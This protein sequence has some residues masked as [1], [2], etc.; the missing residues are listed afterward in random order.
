LRYIIKDCHPPIQNYEIW[1]A[2]YVRRIKLIVIEILKIIHKIGPSYLHELF[3]RKVDFHNVRGSFMVR[4]PIFRTIRY[5]KHSLRYEGVQIWNQLDDDIKRAINLKVFR[6][7]IKKWKG[8][9]CFCFNCTYCSLNL[10]R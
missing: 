8:P 4:T 3:V 9:V 1:L 7:H 5:G 6:R 10:M 2:H